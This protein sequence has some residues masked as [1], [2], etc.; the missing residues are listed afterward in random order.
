MKGLTQEQILKE[1]GLR[2]ETT[3]N[4]DEEA[5]NA[6]SSSTTLINEQP[7]NLD[8][9]FSTDESIIENRDDIEQTTVSG[10]TSSPDATD[11]SAWAIAGLKGFSKVDDNS[12]EYVHKDNKLVLRLFSSKLTNQ[13]KYWLGVCKKKGFYEG[14]EN[15]KAYFFPDEI[16]N[17]V[18]KIDSLLKNHVEDFRGCIA[19]IK[20]GLSI[21]EK[22]RLLSPNPIDDFGSYS[23]EEIYNRLGNWFVKN[24]DDSRVAVFNSMGKTHVCLCQRGD[25]TPA[26]IFKEVF[27]EITE[28]GQNKLGVFKRELFDKDFFIHDVGEGGRDYQL[29]VSRSIQ[30]QLGLA[31]DK[32]ISIKFPE[33]IMTRIIEKHNNINSQ[34]EDTTIWLEDCEEV[35]DTTALEIAQFIIVKPD[36]EVQLYA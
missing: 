11:T 8:D 16:E 13:R 25:R 24:V 15:K 26:K 21:I 10:A 34:K 6:E 4:N 33:E 28:N 29:T 30:S 7:T 35:E 22:N 5:K 1:L 3:M 32:V 17:Q 20:T 9:M 2:G 19:D 23:I 12:A 18:S 27:T 31:N 36:G 14:V